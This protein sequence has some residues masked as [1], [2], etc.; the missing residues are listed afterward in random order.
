MGHMEA[1]KTDV[2]L[3]ASWGSGLSSWIHGLLQWRKLE[4]EVVLSA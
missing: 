3:N 2:L 4:E 1:E